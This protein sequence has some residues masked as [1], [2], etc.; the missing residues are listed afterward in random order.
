MDAFTRLLQES[1]MTNIRQL[2]AIIEPHF[3]RDFLSC[4]PVEVFVL[5]RKE[6]L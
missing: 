1:N 5:K 3:Q 6:K 4:L 2:R